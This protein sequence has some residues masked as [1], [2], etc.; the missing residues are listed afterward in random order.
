MYGFMRQDRK[1]APPKA[2]AGTESD[3]YAM[4]STRRH[5]GQRRCPL[6]ESRTETICR[7][8]VDAPAS[9]LVRPIALVGCASLDSHGCVTPTR[10]NIRG[11]PDIR[12]LR[13]SQ[14]Q[15]VG[16]R[17][18]Y[19]RCS[20][21]R[22]RGCSCNTQTCRFSVC[23]EVHIYMPDLFRHFLPQ[24]VLYNRKSKAWLRHMKLSDYNKFRSLSP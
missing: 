15:A 11:N 21:D 12:R 18:N 13:R 22:C 24:S 14:I 8:G 4:T 20:W 16:I 6:V 2:R 23:T 19:I 17:N 5:Q 1:P 10:L 9:I 7:Q 3:Y